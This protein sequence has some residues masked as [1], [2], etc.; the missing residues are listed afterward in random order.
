[1]EGGRG[2]KAPVVAGHSVMP[3]GERLLLEQQRQERIRAGGPSAAGGGG[4]G[5]G[6]GR[7]GAQLASPPPALSAILNAAAAGT[8]GGS[9]TGPAALN[10]QPQ[11]PLPLLP[12]IMQLAEA[13]TYQFFLAPVS[14]D[15]APGYSSK[16]QS[17]MDLGTYNITVPL[18]MSTAVTRLVC[19]CLLTPCLSPSCPSVP[20][21]IVGTMEERCRQGLFSS[22]EVLAGGGGGGG[23]VET[24]I[25]LNLFRHTL[26]LIWA[27]ACEYVPFLFLLSLHILCSP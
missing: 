4:S 19:L 13:D 16:I 12:L 9:A 17:P 5:G 21:C 27:N 14:D 6:E 23:G 2:G 8:A 26:S 22:T 11:L 20:Q 24:E 18:V 1:M 10:Q 3:T 7:G 25:G 15:I